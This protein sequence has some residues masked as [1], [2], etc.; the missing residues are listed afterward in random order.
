MDSHN[1]RIH[2]IAV[3]NQQIG[4]CLS[5]PTP[6]V[7][8]LTLPFPHFPC[9]EAQQQ[10]QEIAARLEKE[11]K[12]RGGGISQLPSQQQ[13]GYVP[14]PTSSAPTSAPEDD[15]GAGSRNNSNASGGGSGMKL[16]VGSKTS[17]DDAFLQQVAK[18]DVTVKK[19]V[20][21]SSSASFA[22]QGMGA[23]GGAIAEKKAVDFAFTEFISASIDK[24]GEA[25]SVAIKGEM[26]VFISDPARNAIKVRLP[27][28]DGNFSFHTHPA[29]DKASFKANVL[30]PK[31]PASAPFP[32]NSKVK[33]VTWKSKASVD[34]QEM[35][36]LTVS[37]WPS[38][39]SQQTTR[40]NME[41]VLQHTDRIIR[42]LVIR[43]PV[44]SR[45]PPV[46]Q[47]AVGDYKYDARNKILEWSVPLIDSDSSDGSIEFVIGET[48][49]SLFP[50]NVSFEGDYCICAVDALEVADANG[51]VD[52]SKHS[53]I[54]AENYQIVEE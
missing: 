39:D 25:T 40:V 30:A 46:V 13:R 18:Q 48:G 14:V 6:C 26:T 20:G 45:S 36:P 41:Y 31:D 51:P 19:S 11:R 29:V 47:R 12:A 37:C 42:N 15:W 16:S 24:E 32:V 44:A 2:E 22:S 21:A 9:L 1:E 50:I 27:P 3:R 53:N 4:A 5:P 33:V 52:F 17:K 10:A 34:V 7:L 28:A 23:S 43:V 54:T 49:V 8:A 35:V 38:A